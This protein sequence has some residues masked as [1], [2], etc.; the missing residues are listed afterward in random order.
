MAIIESQEHLR[1]WM[2]WAKGYS[3]ENSV[4]FVAGC[5]RDWDAGVAFNYAII[6]DGVIAG[7]C[8][9]M[10]RIGPGA[11]EIGYWVHRDYVRRGLATAS[12][13]ALT[14]AAFTLPDIDRVEIVHDELNRPSEAVPRKLGFTRAGQRTLYFPPRG[15]HR[16][17]H[18][19]APGPPGR[20][21]LGGYGSQ[22]AF[23]GLTGRG[24]ERAALQQDLG[25]QRRVVGHRHVPAAGQGQ[26]PGL[27]QLPLGHHG[28]ARPQQPVLRA[29]GD[30]DRDLVRDDLGER[31]RGVEIALT[32][33]RAAVNARASPAACSGLSRTGG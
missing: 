20:H 26:E 5:D 10:A 6:V 29:P 1:P 12:A 28:L 8:G 14:S 16:P 7:S 4:E 9:L 33:A 15:R 24:R 30:R 13:A 31:Q 11:L 3:R 19:L 32:A 18:R 21:T 22:S 2:P 25:H 17:R 23:P 27:R